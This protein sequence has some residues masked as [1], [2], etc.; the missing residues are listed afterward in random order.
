MLSLHLTA[1][2]GQDAAGL[3]ITSADLRR[4]NPIESFDTFALSGHTGEGVSFKFVGS[5][6]CATE[7][8]A[9]VV[10]QTEKARIVWRQS[11][12]IRIE[13]KQ[14]P[15]ETI[16][17]PKHDATRRHLLE[18]VLDRL[19]GKPCFTC[20]T[21]TA[22]AHARLYIALHQT[23]P[24]RTEPADRVRHGAVSGGACIWIEGIETELLGLLAA[25]SGSANSGVATP[26]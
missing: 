14:G 17:L 5:H 9:E 3:T 20:S 4:A 16:L 26:V 12:L 10:L 21:A 18:A 2:R 8:T 1:P 15:V 11:D 22:A 24:I 25:P 7:T 13:N 23:Y 6:A 19:A